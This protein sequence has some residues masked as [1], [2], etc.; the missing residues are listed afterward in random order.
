MCKQ[1]YNKMFPFLIIMLFWGNLYAANYP[2]EITQPQSNLTTSSRYYKAYPGI[3]Y[4]VPVGLIGG[5]FP[6]TY[7]LTNAPSGM[8]I[9]PTY[10]IIRWP[11]P[12]T[13]GSP[14][15]IAVRVTDSENTTVA[16]SWPITVTTSG[17]IFLD[18]VNGRSGASGTINDPLR[19]MVDVGGSSYEDIRDSRYD[20]Y[21]VY[22]RNGT[23]D[24]AGHLNNSGQQLQLEWRGSYKPLVWL[25]YPGETAVIDHNRSVSGAFFDITDSDN[26]DL[27]IHGI[28]FQDMRNHAIRILGNRQV[29]FECEFENLGPGADGANS[30]FLMFATSGGPGGQRYPFIKDCTFNDLNVGA[31]IKLYSTWKIVIEG[32][33]FSNGSGSPMEGIASKA[34]NQYVDIRA[35]TID[36]IGEHAI[37]GNWNYDAHLEIRFN[38]VKNASDNYGSNIHG[39]LTANY[40]NSAGRV[41]IYRN[42]LEG[43]VTVKWA[44]SDDG[45]FHFHQNVI[46]NRNAGVENSH[47]TLYSVDDPSRVDIGTGA[48]QNISGYPGDGI[49]DSEGNFTPGYESYLGSYGHQV[50]SVPTPR[51]LHVVE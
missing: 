44:T 3:E 28:R 19:N 37:S 31:F 50:S 13:A 42:T 1:I 16:V 49:I 45:P 26:N 2:L 8:T 43:T 35:N 32:S 22:F 30:S 39:A 10:G 27:F 38:N 36:N 15:S 12:S 17:F 48:N 6:F 18:S 29:F 34:Y 5:A 7:E 23:Y 40:H 4:T 51:T 11:N 20:N 24:P 47:I 21:F 25:E 14:H 9:D 33:R 41:F 46:V